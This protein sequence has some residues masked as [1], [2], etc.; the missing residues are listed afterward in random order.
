[1]YAAHLCGPSSNPELFRTFPA[2][3]AIASGYNHTVPNR[4]RLHDGLS[5]ITPVAD[6][7]TGILRG[8]IDRLKAGDMSARH[9]LVLRAYFRLQKHLHTQMRGFERQQSHIESD[10]VRNEV[11]ARFIKA[12]DDVQFD[13]VC[14]YIRFLSVL[15]RRELIDC[16]RKLYGLRGEGANRPGQLAASDAS[17]P[18]GMV[19]P[20]DTAAIDSAH[21]AEL[22]KLYEKLNALPEELRDVVDHLYFAQLTQEEAAESLGISQTEVHRRWVQ[23]RRWLHHLMPNSAVN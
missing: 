10:E 4:R 8:L 22:H 23:A 5:G 3:T 16:T 14:D 15:V 9:D 12:I 11:I 20:I 17:S 1:M 13:R 18:G 7:T 2:N 6:T 19:Q 21:Q